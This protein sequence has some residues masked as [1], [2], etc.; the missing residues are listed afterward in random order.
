MDWTNEQ[1]KALEKLVN[2]LTHPPVF[3]YP[4]FNLPLTLHTDTS[5]QGSR[6]CSL[7]TSGWQVE[8]DWLWFEDVDGRRNKLSLTQWKTGVSGVK[9]GCV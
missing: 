6:G 7:S 3:A 4:D 1:Q 5:D 9:M 8:G 2:L